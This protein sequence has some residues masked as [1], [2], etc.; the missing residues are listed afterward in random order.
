[1]AK[2]TPP[3]PV[4]LYT[5]SSLVSSCPSGAAK[6]KKKKKICKILQIY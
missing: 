4:K 5:S 3:A 1:M 6:R 2:A